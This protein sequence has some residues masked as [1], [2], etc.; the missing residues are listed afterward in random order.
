MACELSNTARRYDA[1]GFGGESIDRVTIRVK[2]HGYGRRVPDSR[3]SE[4]PPA[5]EGSYLRRIRFAKAVL[6]HRL[7]IR[8]LGLIPAKAACQVSDTG[9]VRVPGRCESRTICHIDF[10]LVVQASTTPLEIS[11]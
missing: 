3:D 6:Y 8:N 1:A 7:V 2:R 4:L 11:F 9:P 5:G 10:S